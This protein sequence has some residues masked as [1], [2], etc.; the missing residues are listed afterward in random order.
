MIQVSRNDNLKNG[1]I[2]RKAKLK[3]YKASIRPVMTYAAKTM[4]LTQKYEE[5][6]KIFEQNERQRYS[7]GN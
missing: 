5:R 7:K 6:L 1:K 2:G 3:I 4:C